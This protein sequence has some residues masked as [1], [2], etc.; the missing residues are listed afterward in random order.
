LNDE[1]GTGVAVFATSPTLITPVLGVAS[2]TSFTSNTTRSDTPGAGGI[3]IADV[4]KGSFRLNTSN[5]LAL[6]IY[7]GATW[8][9]VQKWTNSGNTT[10]TG[11]LGINGV[12]NSVTSGTYTPTLTNGTNVASSTTT[13]A[14][15]IRIG[16]QVTVYGTVQVTPTTTP[17]TATSLGISLPIASNFAA[18][19]NLIGVL[20]DY[21]NIGY[22]SALLE[23]DATNDR[24]VIN[25]IAEAGSPRFDYSFMYTVQ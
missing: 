8:L 13:V 24:A 10:I 21:A 1:T 2:G 14:Q 5:E 15:Y 17:A 16:N 6:D 7:N 12:A 18:A 9:E 19:S 23:A 22:K 4:A 20:S 11:T 25:F 3:T